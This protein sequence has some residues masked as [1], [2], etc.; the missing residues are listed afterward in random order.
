M[1]DVQIGARHQCVNTVS[2]TEILVSNVTYRFT[3]K[4]TDYCGSVVFFLFCGAA[5][6]AIG[7]LATMSLMKP[8]I[9]SDRLKLTL[10]KLTFS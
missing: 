4:A 1:E 6:L 10:K 3:M 7:K 9:T 5:M 2:R 8:L